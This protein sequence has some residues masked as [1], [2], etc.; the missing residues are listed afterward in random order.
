MGEYMVIGVVFPVALVGGF[1]VG[2][3]IGALLGAATAGALVG[4]LLGTVAA[5]YNLYETLKRIER[6]EAVEA[7]EREGPEV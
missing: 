3:W 2:R 7:R 5:F 1:F 4:L 6:R